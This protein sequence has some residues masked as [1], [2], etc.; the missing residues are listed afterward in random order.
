VGAHGAGWCIERDVL[1]V[2]DDHR[3]SLDDS[4]AVEC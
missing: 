2:D 3:F 1:V 4:I